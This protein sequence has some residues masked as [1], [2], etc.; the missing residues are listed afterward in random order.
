MMQHRMK[1]VLVDLIVTIIFLI[2]FSACQQKAFQQP[3][4]PTAARET[5]PWSRWWWHGNSVTKEGITIEMEGYKKAGLGGLEITP[6]YGVYGDEKN[7]VNYLTP[8]WIELFLHTLREA[9]RL[10]MGIDM[11]TGTGWPF[12]GPWVSDADACKNIEYKVYELNEGQSITEKIEFIQQP[13]LRAV[14]NLI[15]EMHEGAV[16]EDRLS[17]GTT[18]EP[19]MRIDP[20][21]IDIRKIKQPVSSNKNL[22][23]LALDQVKFEKPLALKTLRAFD[24]SGN[25]VDLIDKMKD[26]KLNWVAPKGKWKV[27]AVFE[28]WHGKMVE[29]AGPGGEGNVIDHFSGS[30]LKNYL[31]QFDSAL[32]GQDISSLRAFF[33]D[34]YEVDD[35]RGAADWTPDL[36]ETF[37]KRCG[38]DLR[39]HIPSWLG[40]NP[41]TE[42]NE[43]I[44]S[45]YRETISELVLNNFTLP[46][47]AWARDKDAIIRNQAHGSPSNILDLYAAVDIPEIEGTEPLRIKMASS[48][49]N[50]AGKKL[51]SSESAT[52]LNEHFESNL[53]DIRKAVNLFF[54]SGV[55]HVFY[56]GTCYSPQEE[57]WPGR[58]FYAAVHLNP[59]N[60]LWNDFDALNMY[61]T[62]CQSF[63]QQSHAD[64]DI[65]LYFPIYDRFATHGPEMIEHF[66]GLGKQFENSLFKKS[67]ELMLDSGYTFD[68]ISDKQI[69][70][71]A[72]LNDGI[73]TEG[74]NRYKTIVIPKCKYIP[75][76]TLQHVLTLAEEGN[77]LIFYGGI[78]YS[79]SGYQNFTGQQKIFSELISKL[80]PTGQT[81][82]GK[83][84]ILIGN[85]LQDLLQQAAIRRETLVDSGLHFIRK[86][87]SENRSQYFVVNNNS[88]RY[89]GWI[90]LQRDAANVVFMDPMSGEIGKAKI[91]NNKETIEVYLQLSAGESV[92]INLYKED[93]TAPEHKYASTTGDSILL[94]GPWTVSFTQGGPTLPASVTIDSLLSWTAFPGKDYSIFSG[95]AKYSI[96]FAKPSQSSSL[97]LDLGRVCESADVILNGKSLTTLIGPSYQLLID[98]SLIK[99]HNV[100]EVHV[101]NLMANRIIDLDKR[102]VLWRK[103]YNVN[104]PARKAENR[105]NGLF[106]AA[107]W[108][109]KTSGLLGPVRLKLIKPTA[110]R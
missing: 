78:P 52:W 7:F 29:R 99:E 59:R 67:A 106:S 53:G 16:T 70:N 50:I 46:W 85:D 92:F 84:T 71:T 27:Y 51:V 39:D 32:A 44:L 61:V 31:S 22:Q 58:L 98:E 4:W 75:L 68:F 2:T 6:I 60:S 102:N 64:N 1:Q 57:P 91:R 36:F 96:E 73:V 88:K 43:R 90:P 9:E 89:D 63:L 45:D 101:S 11:A 23:E 103:F 13:F 12:G 8:Q 109:P 55:N 42:M 104:F 28:G 93:V 25:V 30:A 33:N 74:G 81:K 108:S 110:I 105:V 18:K 66:D 48:A 35:A 97:M 65:L 47:K 107:H 15:Y 20:K 10:D 14:G 37:N 41:N 26:A 54:L 56:H 82:I 77:T 69:L 40:H 87:T 95:T 76:K 24:E 3:D 19:K 79:F 17:H 62:R 38:Y 86:I 83:G 80:P 49:G 5:K 94:N 72:N 100:L 21:M 34:S